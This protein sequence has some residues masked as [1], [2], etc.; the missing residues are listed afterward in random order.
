MWGMDNDAD[1]VADCW[2]LHLDPVAWSKVRGER[3]PAIARLRDPFPIPQV[4]IPAVVPYQP[5]VWHVVGAWHPA[6]AQAQLLV[7]GGCTHNMFREPEPRPFCVDGTAVVEFGELATTSSALASLSF[8]N[9]LLLLQAF[10]PSTSCV[11]STWPPCTPCSPPSSLSASPS[12]QSGT[13]NCKC[14]LSRT[15]VIFVSPAC[16]L[17][18]LT[19]TQ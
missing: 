19:V 16:D 17:Q 5:R 2:L 9:A 15:I 10:P 14:Q 1:P 3:P 12:T 8:I 4:H 13:L 7:F 6:P 18:T 11:C